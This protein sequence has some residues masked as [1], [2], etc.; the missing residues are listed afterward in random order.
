MISVKYSF[1][2]FCEL[3]LADVFYAQNVTIDYHSRTEYCHSQ[4]CPRNISTFIIKTFFCLIFTLKTGLKQH[5]CE[6][7]Q[8][9]NIWLNNF[10]K[11]CKVTCIFMHLMFQTGMAIESLI[12]VSTFEKTSWNLYI[13]FQSVT[14]HPAVFRMHSYDQLLTYSEVRCGDACNFSLVKALL[15]AHLALILIQY[16]II[17]KQVIRYD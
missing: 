6:W 16:L 3:D 12:A 5:N 4:W 7:W 11:V 10:F 9:F 17:S 8:N 2:L 1:S 13:L 14:L 15:Q